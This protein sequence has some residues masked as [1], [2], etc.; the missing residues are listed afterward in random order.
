MV[1]QEVVSLPTQ[2]EWI[3]ITCCLS[4]HVSGLRLSQHRESGLKFKDNVRVWILKTSLP[5]Q[6]EW[7]E[8][9]AREEYNLPSSLSQHRESGLKFQVQQRC[10]GMYKSL[11]TQGEWIEITI[12]IKSL[13][14]FCS[15]SQHRESGLKFFCLVVH[16]IPFGLS[17][18]RE[19]GLKYQMKTKAFFHKVSPNTGRVD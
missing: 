2:G 9:A 5:T 14:I 10:H 18:H 11:P 4:R 19:S 7:I 15:L 13:L 6:G 3:E 17:Q 12:D 8:I 1:S 16:L